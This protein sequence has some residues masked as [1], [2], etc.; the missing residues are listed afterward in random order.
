M[1]ETLINTSNPVREERMPG[2]VGHALAGVEVRVVD[3]TGLHTSPGELGNI[4][5]RGPNVFRGY[6]RR[7]DLTAEEFRDDGWFKS[8]EI[9]KI[10]ENGR[11]C[12]AG[13]AKDLIITGALDVY[14]AEVETAIEEMEHIRDCAVIGTYHPDLGE[15]VVAIV[16][17]D[18]SIGTTDVE[19]FLRDRLAGFEHPKPVVRVDVIPWD[20]MGKVHKTELRKQYNTLFG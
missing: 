11:L 3:S 19:Q 6:W 18:R 8:G 12:V 7:P 5:V 13:R 14:P 15:A 20:A 16:C 9:G 10:D 1:T 17:S 2:C 4:E